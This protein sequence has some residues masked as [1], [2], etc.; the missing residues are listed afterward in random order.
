[1]PFTVKTKTRSGYLIAFI[2]LLVSYFLIFYTVQNL[3]KGTKAVTHTYSIINKLE[4]L[5]SEVMEAETGA[6]G[7]VLTSDERF[8]EPYTRAIKAIPI[9][10]ED[11]KDESYESSDQQAKLAL[12]Y[13]VIERKLAIMADGIRQFREAGLNRTPEMQARREASRVAM[14][15]IRMLIGQLESKEQQA[16]TD[17]TVTLTGSFN[18][19]DVIALISLAIAILTIIYSLYTYN[20]ENKAKEIAD[21]KAQ[22]Y[23]KE[24]ENKLQELEQ[25]N[26][27]LKELKT[28]E[29]FAATGRIARTIAHEV[30][31]PLT[32]ISLATEQ[33]SEA[34]SASQN[35]ESPF[36][37]DMI[38]RNA[39]R[40]NQLVSDL[41][42]ST[43]FAQLD[44]VKVDINRVVDETLEMAR[45]RIDLN[46]IHVDKKYM[47]ANCL[48]AV[49]P[50]KLKLA[51]LNIIVNAIESME[52]EKGVLTI[53]TSVEGDKC[54]IEI[55]DNGG[56]MDEDALQKIFE[57]YF[58]T[59][60]KGA[61]L[62][63]TNTQNIILNHRGNISVSSQAGEGTTFSV[64][65]SLNEVPQ[66]S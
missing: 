5:K 53:R 25:V 32:N 41:L 36:L 45:D 60:S 44:F 11:L 49:D 38:R 17:H 66:M 26:A 63:L 9:I 6:R 64:A 37:L 43:R 1:M 61:G 14:D 16:M 57:P 23:Q 13:T 4:S 50:E 3:I 33:L 48:V 2:L 59:K 35:E 20:R 51:L 42:H 34:A 29:K 8:L 18:N 19:T 65:L 46:H 47:R 28:I 40:I 21:G 27:E 15:S 56:G 7:F 54:L 12:L 62:G 24:L 52:K 58:T 22:Q 30:R 55:S 10:Y 39:T 31:N